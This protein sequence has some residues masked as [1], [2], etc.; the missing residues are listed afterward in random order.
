M[1]AQQAFP[2]WALCM[3]GCPR[4]QDGDKTDVQRLDVGCHDHDNHN[5]PAE[6]VLH[7]GAAPAGK[8]CSQW[9]AA[10]RLVHSMDHATDTLCRK[11]TRHWLPH[12]MWVVRDA[13][14][15]CMSAMEDISHVVT[16][17]I[18][19]CQIVIRVHAAIVMHALPL[20]A[21]AILERKD[22]S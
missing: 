20:R 4:Q 16:L 3:Q 2:N 14:H 12:L 18:V 9:I 19:S 17:A 7:K 21:H 13:V 15:V 10:K 5:L 6:V 8:A 22:S 11:V 1:S